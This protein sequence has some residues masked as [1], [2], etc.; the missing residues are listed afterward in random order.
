MLCLQKRKS[1]KDER[2]AKKAAREG[3]KPFKVDS[4]VQEAL[5]GGNLTPNQVFEGQAILG[6]GL[7]FSVCILEGFI[8]AASV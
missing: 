4:S 2:K 6:L 8:V 1:L 7:I 5:E 3:E